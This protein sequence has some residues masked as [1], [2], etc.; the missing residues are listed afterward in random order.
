MKSW[1]LNAF[2]TRAYEQGNKVRKITFPKLCSILENAKDRSDS[3]EESKLSYFSK[4]SA[5][6]I[7]EFTNDKNFNAFLFINLRMREARNTLP[8]SS[9]GRII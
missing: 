3:T 6:C 4:Y 7:D 2:A 1:F 5:V 8:A 9:A